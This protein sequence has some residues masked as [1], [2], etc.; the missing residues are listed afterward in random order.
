MATNI[1]PKVEKA[2]QEFRVKFQ[3]L[4]DE[5]GKAIVGHDEIVEGVLTC[6][7]AGGHALL[8]GVPGLGSPPTSCRRTSSAR[9]ISPGPGHRPS[10]GV[11]VPARGRS[12]RTSSWPTRS[13]APA[14]DAVGP[15]R[16]DAGAQVTVGDD[17]TQ[18]ARAV[19]RAGHAEPHRAG[20]RR[21]VVAPHV[22]DYVIR[23]TLATHPDGR[24]AVD[25]T[26][27]YIRWG[28]S[29]RAAQAITLGAKT[30]AML[31]GRYNVSF[32]DAQKVFLPALRHR[33]LLNF[34][35]EAEGISTDNV[36]RE[37]IEKTPTMAEAAA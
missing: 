22:Q 29:P 23:L 26:N 6:L 2:T 25:A 14:Q 27:R 18:A 28:G 21:L 34:E 11:R 20:V 15:A 17:T 19:L 13:T 37:I 9:T 31:D 33:V 30:Q 5:I 7:F 32:S 10:S 36:L 8:E 24:F 3:R 35:G 16:G 4:R 1:D 12:S